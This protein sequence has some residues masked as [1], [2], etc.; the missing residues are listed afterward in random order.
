MRPVERIFYKPGLTE[1]RMSEGNRMSW[2]EDEW[3]WIGLYGSLGY[4]AGATALI[5]SIFLLLG[6][7]ALLFAVYQGWRIKRGP[8]VD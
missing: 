6:L 7:G 5:A 8:H 3:F 2:Q 1:R 4:F